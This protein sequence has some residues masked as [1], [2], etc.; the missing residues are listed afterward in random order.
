[1]A[2][3]NVRIPA[4]NVVRQLPVD[5]TRHTPMH[6]II[7]TVRNGD[8][9][10]AGNIWKMTKTGRVDDGGPEE[11]LDYFCSLD[12]NGISNGDTV[13]LEEFHL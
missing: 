10:S 13:A 8:A 6:V 12:A 3:I 9:P 4:T 2:Q 11:V 1:M 7:Q 5:L